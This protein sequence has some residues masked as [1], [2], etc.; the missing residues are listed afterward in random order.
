M[1]V[2]YTVYPQMYTIMFVSCSNNTVISEESQNYIYCLNFAITLTILKF[3]FYH[4]FFL[5]MDHHVSQL[6]M[7]EHVT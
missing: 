1:F 6:K 7:I 4:I 3:L 5:Q 2:S